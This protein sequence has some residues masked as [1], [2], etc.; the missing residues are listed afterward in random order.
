MKLIKKESTLY[1][2]QYIDT[3]KAIKKLGDIKSRILKGDSNFPYVYPILEEDS[4][5]K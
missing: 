5:E 4:E 3:I 1:E 2:Q